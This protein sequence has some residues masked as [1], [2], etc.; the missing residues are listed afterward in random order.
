MVKGE[1]GAAMAGGLNAHVRARIWGGK[2]GEDGAH[3]AVNGGRVRLCP[4]EEERGWE[5]EDG[6]GRWDF[7]PT[8]GMAKWRVRVWAV[9]S[10][11]D[12]RQRRGAGGRAWAECAAKRA[13]GALEMGRTEG[14]RPKGGFGF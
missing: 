10:P 6:A 2:G 1:T 11:S 13:G 9:G 14:M 7:D 5:G 12:G 3:A 4:R 8:A